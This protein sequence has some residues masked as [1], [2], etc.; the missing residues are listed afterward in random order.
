MKRVKITC[1]ITLVHSFVRVDIKQSKLQCKPT[2]PR[3]LTQKNFKFTV[4]EFSFKID[5]RINPTNL[6]KAEITSGPTTVVTE[7]TTTTT[8]IIKSSFLSMSKTEGSEI[9]PQT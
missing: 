4:K 1:S 8:T 9:T 7:A 5:F 6:L 3:W 2:M